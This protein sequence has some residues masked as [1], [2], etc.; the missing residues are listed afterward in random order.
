[1]TPEPLA[2]FIGGRYAGQ[3]AYVAKRLR[4]VYDRDYAAS[5][6]ATPLSLSL[7]IDA[8]EIRGARV[9]GW[10]DGLLP[11]N[12]N[13][14]E[15]WAGRHSARSVAPFDLLSTPIGLDCPGAVQT[16]PLSEAALIEQRRGG[17]DWLTD[18]HL[19]GIIDEIVRD[20]AWARR[21]LRAGYSLAGAQGKT[22]LCRDGDR[23]GEPW[24]VTPSTYILKPSM[25]DLPDQALNEHLCLTA[26]R[27]CGLVAAHS[28][29]LRIGEHVVVAVAR[30]DRVVAE[31]G[32]IRRVHQE[33]FHQA[34]GVPSESIYQR[35]GRG[36]SVRRLARLLADHSVDRDTDRQ[37]FF[38]ALVF[39]WVVCSIDAHAKNYSLLIGPR[40]NA[41]LAPLYD[42][43]SYKPYDP[44]HMRSH[45]M[46]MSAVEDKRILAAEEPATWRATAR[47]VGLDA[48]DAPERAAEI[49]ALVPAAFQ[50]AVDE[51][52]EHLRASPLA[53]ELT[54]H[55]ATRGT[56][57]QA[58]LVLAPAAKHT[59]IVAP[60][61]T[62]QQ[63]PGDIPL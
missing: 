3:I 42:I 8:G 41:R 60:A 14:R 25:R 6:S 1:M 33:D 19:S 46:A 63:H 49:A 22:A 4:L 39:N 31:D 45:T 48:S 5:S 10:L 29:A 16:C 34:C 24:G 58:T 52:P 13:V 28:D 59:R 11:G 12:E 51:L 17:V 35:E 62:P 18:A 27:Y 55:M 61:E 44:Q 9:A 23:W 20:Q 15:D 7:P 32:T 54:K 21:H 26:A 36:H 43:W 37:R 30:Y 40:G 53:A 47:A 38:D 56:E 2:V 57:C 50:R